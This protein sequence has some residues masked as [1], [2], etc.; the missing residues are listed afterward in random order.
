MDTQP[1]GQP[2]QIERSYERKEALRRGDQFTEWDSIKYGGAMVLLPLLIL[3]G[4][5]LFVWSWLA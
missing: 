2:F 5:V 1:T 3:V 4:A